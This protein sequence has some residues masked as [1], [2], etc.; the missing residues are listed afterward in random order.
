MGRQDWAWRG[1]ASTARD[2]PAGRSDFACPRPWTSSLSPDGRSPGRRRRGFHLGSL[3]GLVGLVEHLIVFRFFSGGRLGDTK[4][5]LSVQRRD[6]IERDARRGLSSAL[7]YSRLPPA[8]Q[9]PL[10]RP[11]GNLLAWIESRGADTF[12][13]SFIGEGAVPDTRRGFRGRV[14]AQHM[15][16]S[17]NDARYWVK[18]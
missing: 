10:M 3:K 6:S 13:A 7:L 14:P 11:S 18:E 9:P 16:P 1:N 2:R 15:C 5:F 12:V 8:P 4:L 17:A